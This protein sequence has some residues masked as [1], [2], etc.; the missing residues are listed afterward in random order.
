M[1][2][3]S[4]LVDEEIEEKCLTLIQHI[5]LYIWK[6]EDYWYF[7]RFRLYTERMEKEMMQ[8]VKHLVLFLGFFRFLSFF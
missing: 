6:L 5:Y 2:E 4:G 7:F 8:K 3:I 1:E